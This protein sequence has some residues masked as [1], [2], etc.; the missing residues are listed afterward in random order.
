MA[1]AI[2]I[3]IAIK[4][5][6]R[7]P[8]IP[9]RLTILL[10]SRAIFR[11]DAEIMIRELEIIFRQNPIALKLR[12]TRQILVLLQHLRCIATGTVIDPAAIILATAI[13]LR[14][15]TASTPTVRLTIV[16]QVI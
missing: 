4:P 9:T 16:K 13:S 2:I 5:V 12:L 6:I 8:L 3:A 1:A 14:P 7:R 15:T 11:P 10:K